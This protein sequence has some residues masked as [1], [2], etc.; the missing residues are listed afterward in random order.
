M[1]T[2]QTGEPRVYTGE[3][4][5]LNSLW[6]SWTAPINANYILDTRGT[7]PNGAN[8]FDVQIALYT[9]GSTFAGLTQLRAN[10]DWNQLPPNGCNGTVPLGTEWAGSSCVTFTSVAGTTYYFQVDGFSSQVGAFFLNLS[11][12]PLAAEVSVGGRIT[13]N[14]G[15]GI[16]RVR[17]NLTKP[18]GE[19]LTAMTNVFGYYKFENLEAGQTYI[20]QVN[21]KRFQFQNNPRVLTVSENLEG[22]DFT[23]IDEFQRE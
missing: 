2:G 1:T 7:N 23:A 21:S 17:V 20:L 19:I 12:A 16:P 11:L 6:Y 3:T 14:N 18:S 15:S 8:N 13:D 9:G 5:A 4:T 22:E 10:D